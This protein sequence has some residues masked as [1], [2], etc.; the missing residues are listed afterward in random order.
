MLMNRYSEEADLLCGQCCAP[1]LAML[2][3]PDIYTA[4]EV[5]GRSCAGVL[6]ILRKFKYVEKQVNDAQWI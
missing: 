2:L 3:M 1:A 4:K 5:P 6:K